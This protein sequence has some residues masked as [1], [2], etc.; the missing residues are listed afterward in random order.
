[1]ATFWNAAGEMRKVKETFAKCERLE[2]H[3][4]KKDINNTGF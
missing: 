3:F 4:E 1:M 2:K